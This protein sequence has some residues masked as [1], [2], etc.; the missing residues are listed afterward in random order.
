MFILNPRC[1]QQWYCLYKNKHEIHFLSDML[2]N[3]KIG[4]YDMSKLKKKLPFNRNTTSHNQPSNDAIQPLRW[5]QPLQVVRPAVS[6]LAC[7]TTSNSTIGKHTKSEIHRKNK[8]S[9]TW[10][11][12]KQATIWKAIVRSVG[13]TR[14]KRREARNREGLLQRNKIISDY[15][16]A[17]KN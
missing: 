16:C 11:S 6:C 2:T 4:L 3:V 8:V 17:R 14:K 7:I 15:C 5:I 9:L 12:R 1:A 13:R 10:T